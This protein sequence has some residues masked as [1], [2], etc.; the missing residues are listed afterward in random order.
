M[1][2][3]RAEAMKRWSHLFLGFSLEQNTS[4]LCMRRVRFELMTVQM[5]VYFL[6][7]KLLYA[8]GQH[9]YYVF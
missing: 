6:C 7:S 3:Y 5:H 4:I 1:Y 2:R 8:E 9:N